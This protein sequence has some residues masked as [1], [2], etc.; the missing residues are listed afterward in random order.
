[1]AED[2]GKNPPL[3]GVSNA[4]LD[5]AI[6]SRGARGDVPTTPFRRQPTSDRGREG[7]K[8]ETAAKILVELQR[9]MH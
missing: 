5:E 3:R 8:T 7:G 2:K 4:V 6:N 1:M 9:W